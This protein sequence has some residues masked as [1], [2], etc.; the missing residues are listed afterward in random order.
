VSGEGPQLKENIMVIE[1]KHFNEII[2]KLNDDIKSINEEY[3]VVTTIRCDGYYNIVR[4]IYKNID[5]FKKRGF[6]E[7]KKIDKMFAIDFS[8]WTYS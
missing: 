5:D 6:L 1:E 3:C 4:H 7:S 8:I 2:E